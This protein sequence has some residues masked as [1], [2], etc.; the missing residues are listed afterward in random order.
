LFLVSCSLFLATA[1]ATA[2]VA[3]TTAT[4]V[5]YI[6]ARFH[7]YNSVITVIVDSLKCHKRAW[8]T[9]EHRKREIV[10]SNE[11]NPAPRTLQ[12]SFFHELTH[13]LLEHCKRNDLSKDEQF[14]EMLS[15]GI[16][17]FIEQYCP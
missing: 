11:G 5:A 7:L 4:T 16:Q 3:A 6:P 8:A 17:Q 10:I 15:V 2:Q 12:H 9:Y 1:T 14:V 13:C